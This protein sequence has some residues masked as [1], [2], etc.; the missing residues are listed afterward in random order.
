MRPA[1]RCQFGLPRRSDGTKWNARTDSCYAEYRMKRDQ[2][3]S[4]RRRDH[5]GRG[6]PVDWLCLVASSFV[7]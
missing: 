2:D 1:M 5:A 7:C 3:A 4:R 6:K